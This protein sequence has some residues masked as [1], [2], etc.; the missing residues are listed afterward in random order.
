MTNT[1]IFYFAASQLLHRFRLHPKETTE[2]FM[3]YTD[4][5]HQKAW[6]LLQECDVQKEQRLDEI[7]IALKEVHYE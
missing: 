6:N 2:S 3:H 1:D 5:S 7:I 4:F